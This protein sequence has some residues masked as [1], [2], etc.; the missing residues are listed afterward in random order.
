MPLSCR[1]LLL[2]FFLFGLTTALSGNL[3]DNHPV[4]LW[5]VKGPGHTERSRRETNINTA[6]YM[7]MHLFSEEFKEVSHNLLTPIYGCGRCE[8]IFVVT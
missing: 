4:F 7:G 2:L 6:A 3:L 1:F 5:G 8:S